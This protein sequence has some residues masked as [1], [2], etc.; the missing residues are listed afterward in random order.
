[1][2]ETGTDV[3]YTISICNYNMVDTLE[4]SLESILGQVD[5]RFEVLIVDDGSTDGSQSLLDTMANKYDQLRTLYLK[6]D[7]G[8][9]LGETRNISV[10]EAEGE[11]VLLDLDADD[12]YPDG[13]IQDFVYIFHE[14]ERVVG[15]EKVIQ[16]PGIRM[17]SREFFLEI[18][19]YRNLPVGGEDMDLWRRLIGEDKLI[20]IDTPKPHTSIGYEKSP[21]ALIKRW[22]RVAVADFQSGI[23]LFSYLKW[24]LANHSAKRIGYYLLSLPIAYI[25]ATRRDQY[26]IPKS[27]REKGDLPKHME[28]VKTPL[29]ELETEYGVQIDR[30]QLS[31]IGRQI[32]FSHEVE[33]AGTQ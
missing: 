17:A 4:E 32:L 21:K 11:Y 5:D 24:T 30:S 3:T 6:P 33:S 23:S 22:Y 14:I 1:M 15:R 27:F 28:A 12:I 18:G 19:P 13:I 26:T 20:Y 16:I 8:R 31:K 2:D 10:R 7:T 29:S 9:K 25:D